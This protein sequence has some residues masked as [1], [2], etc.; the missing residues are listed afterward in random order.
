LLYN[1]ISIKAEQAP[2]GYDDLLNTSWKGKMLFD[3]EAGYILAA[4]E[5]AWEKPKPSIT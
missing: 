3:P 2:K 1:T 5:D 4:M